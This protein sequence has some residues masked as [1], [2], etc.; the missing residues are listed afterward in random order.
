MFISG[1]AFFFVD[2]TVQGALR[3]TEHRIPRLWRLENL[4]ENEALLR[5]HPWRVQ[6][7]VSC[8]PR[9]IVKTLSRA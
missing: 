4:R 2:G 5:L 7:A 8:D 3:C 9:S 6:L 1:Q